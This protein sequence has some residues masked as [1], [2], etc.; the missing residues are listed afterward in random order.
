M[1][2]SL[3]FENPI[4]TKELRT[5]MRGAKAFWI[6][7][8]YLGLLSVIL[9]GTYLSWL[10]SQEQQGANATQS[11]DMGRM[12]YGVIFAARATGHGAASPEPSEELAMRWVAFDEALAMTADGRITD[13]M[14]IMGLQ[15]I[16]LER[17]TAGAHEEEHQR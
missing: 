16:A 4:L 12:F 3:S 15:R 5:R 9:G 17:A 11:Y 2:F 8:L 6:L 13:A 1:A 7:L 14:S 10:V